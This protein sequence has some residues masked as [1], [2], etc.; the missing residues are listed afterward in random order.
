M[1]PETVNA[2]HTDGQALREHL[3]IEFARGLLLDIVRPADDRALP[4]II[5]LHGGAWRMGD[6]SWRPDFARYFARSGFVMISID[7]TLS[8]DAVFPRQLLD[9]RAGIRWVREHASEHGIL[10][11]SIGLWGSSAGGH[12]AALAGLH[13]GARAILGEPEGAGSAAVQA[14]MD[15][16]G[17]GDL[18]APD[19][20]NPPT[21]GL[22]GGSPGERRELA[23][24]ASPAR[25]D[26]ASAPPFLIMHGAADDLVPASQSIALYEALA[27]GGT[28]ATL[29]LIDGFG[30][31][32]LNPAGL[33]EVAPGPRLDSGRL[34]SDPSATAKLRSTSGR[35]WPASASFGVIEEFFR[36]N[37]GGPA[38][39]DEA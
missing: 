10:A 7:Y 27:A 39:G 16:Y 12:L 23:T 18:L 26:V 37:L 24:L 32:F 15:G 2:P 13:G 11:D 28:D 36:E 29:Y 8:G 31:G 25:T 22:L 5:W 35:A 9:V 17:A 3:A 33:D 19:Q 14:V 4:A 34:E 38:A 21:A 30:H 1:A 6:R 20:D